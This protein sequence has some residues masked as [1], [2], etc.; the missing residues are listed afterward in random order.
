MT[1]TPVAFTEED[2]AARM[3]RAA[4]DAAANGDGRSAPEHHPHRMPIVA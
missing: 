4:R 3:D 1:G 2:Y